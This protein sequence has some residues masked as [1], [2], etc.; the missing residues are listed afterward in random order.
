MNLDVGSYNSVYAARYMDKPGISK[1]NLLDVTNVIASG[2]RDGKYK[3]VGFDIMEFNMHFLG[4]ETPGNV[5]DSTL[6]LVGE[7]IKALT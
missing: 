3:I 6:S 1:Q 2:S 5:K 7:F 4:I